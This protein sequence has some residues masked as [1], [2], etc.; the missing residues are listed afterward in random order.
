[1]SDATDEVNLC[2]CG[3]GAMLAAC[4]GP[5]LDGTPA[6]TAEQLMRSRYTAYALGRG[7][8]LRQSWHPQTR[9]SRVHIDDTRWLSLSINSTEKGGADDASCKVSFT[10]AFMDK[11]GCKLLHETS[12]FEKIDAHWYYLDGVCRIDS[13][14]RNDPC[15]CGSGKKFKRCCG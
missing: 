5:L 14:G 9:P 2:P 7:D 1:M 8:Y 12:R 4:C 3:S 6:R 10:A 13:P 15:P 11:D